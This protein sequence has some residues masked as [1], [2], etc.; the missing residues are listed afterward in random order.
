MTDLEDLDALLPT[1]LPVLPGLAVSGAYVLGGAVRTPRGDGLAVFALPDGR[2]GLL[3]CDAPGSGSTAVLVASRMLG[4]IRASVGTGACLTEA[5][6]SVDAYVRA[7]PPARGTGVTLAALDTGSGDLEVVCAGQDP[8]LVCPADGPPRALPLPTSRP[9]GLGGTASTTSTHLPVGTLLLLHT[10]GLLER[11]GTSVDTDG[12][13]LEHALAT[14]ANELNGQPM[15]LPADLDRVTQELLRAMQRPAGFRDDVAVL[16]AARRSPPQPWS[17]HLPAEEAAVT[18]AV[19]ELDAWLGALGAGLLDR[20]ALRHAVMQ[21]GTNAVRHAYPSMPREPLEMRALLDEQ[22]DVSV[23]VSDHGTW[24]SPGGPSAGHGLVLAG[25]LVDRLTIHRR[26]GG[27]TVTLRQALGRPVPL[28]G[29][30][31]PGD[32]ALTARLDEP[33]TCRSTPGSLAV[34]GAVDDDTAD[35]FA[36]ALH[37]ATRAGTSDCVVDLSD[38]TQLCGAGVVHLFGSRHRAEANGS[39]FRLRCPPGAPVGRVLRRVALDDLVD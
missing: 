16:V 2:T 39:H 21:V 27:T 32:D 9:L 28:Y 17:R 37:S 10:G 35:E 12:E 6:S 7:D 36:V 20:L 18:G 19:G 4:V 33:L 11:W 22:G 34:T 8:P 38:V 14:G 25:G 5:M 24:L 31:V 3:V 13:D 23:G 29:A 26:A 1:T 15:T 30:M